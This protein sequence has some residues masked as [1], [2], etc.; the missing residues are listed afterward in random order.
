MLMDVDGADW[1]GSVLDTAPV[2]Q[3]APGTRRGGAARPPGIGRGAIARPGRARRAGARQFLARRW[4]L[5]TVLGVQAA[6]SLRLVWSNTAF[7][8]EAL[9][10]RAGHLEWA[11]WLHGTAIPDFSSY[12]SGAPILYPPVGALADSVGGL[13][14]ARILSLCFMLAVTTLLWA[15]TSRLFGQ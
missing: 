7:Q 3:A 2:R 1:A 9:Y 10:L 14:A 11:H 6:L 12:F 13:A 4:P 8:D 15:T 5:L